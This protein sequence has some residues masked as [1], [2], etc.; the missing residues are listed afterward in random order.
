M[1]GGGGVRAG[2]F[3]SFPH[4]FSPLSPVFPA[5]DG[6]VRL[7]ILLWRKFVGEGGSEVAVVQGPRETWV[8]R[9]NVEF[10]GARADCGEWR[11]RL[12]GGEPGV[13]G[14]WG[15]GCVCVWV[16]LPLHWAGE[17]RVG[18]EHPVHSSGVG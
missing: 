16:M 8:W 2:I 1:G 15:C 10:E 11:W 17:S 14:S 5:V 9:R 6:R 13:G 3:G 7:V 18:V 4:P 12:L